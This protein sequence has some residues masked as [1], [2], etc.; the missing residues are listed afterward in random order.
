MRTIF[1]ILGP[2]TNPAGA[3]RQLTGT[4]TAALIRPM[5]ETLRALGS[6]KAWLVHGGDGTDE[7]SIAT[8]TAVAALEGARAGKTLEQVME[9][10]GKVIT[11]NDVMDGVVEMIP[12]VQVE[13][14]F[15]DGSRL[16]TVHEP[17]K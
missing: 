7:I 17:I 13:G 11:R 2:L 6:E 14:V 8:T 1:N 10:A 5:A 3:K 16:I 12:Y 15:T 9:L 4:F